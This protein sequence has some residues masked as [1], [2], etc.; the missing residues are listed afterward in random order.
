LSESYTPTSKA[1]L[2]EF[3]DLADVRTSPGTP[4][5]DLDQ[6]PDEMTATAPM[7]VPA[8]TP[9]PPIPPTQPTAPPTQPPVAATSQPAAPIEPED[10]APSPHDPPTPRTAVS[11]QTLS[12]VAP[13]RTPRRRSSRSG[14]MVLLAI[15]VLLILLGA[16][17]G[18][19]L[20]R[21]AGITP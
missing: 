14:G 3:D 6:P 11:N 19:M 8:P 16:G 21:M 2:S 7:S 13:G 9:P 17:I 20:F 12:T 10:E 15:L 1:D 4:I 5:L 18:F